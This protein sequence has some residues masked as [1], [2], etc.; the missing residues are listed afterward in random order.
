M[1]KTSP[2][3]SGAPSGAV[4]RHQ[5]VRQD[6][7]TLRYATNREEKLN[8]RSMLVSLAAMRSRSL[9]ELH[10]L[11]VLRVGLCDV[12]MSCDGYRDEWTIAT[13]YGRKSLREAMVPQTSGALLDDSNC[14]CVLELA[15]LMFIMMV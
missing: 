5:T 9:A 3:L 15:R 14:D 10:N 6:L 7:C 2:G 12:A 13:Y 11:L 8:E 1:L 4:A